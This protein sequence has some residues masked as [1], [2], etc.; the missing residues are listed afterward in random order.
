MSF[1]TTLIPP[2]APPPV[3]PAR[4]TASRFF[5]NL[6]MGIWLALGVGIFMMITGGWD[7]EKFTRYGPNYLSGLGVT[8]MLV[9]ASVLL[10][11]LLSL[12]LAFARMSKNP[13]FAWLSYA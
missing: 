8:L 2:Q 13:V 10:G 7:V 9:T 5:G 4:Y 12:P 6:F 3:P 11:G 1:V